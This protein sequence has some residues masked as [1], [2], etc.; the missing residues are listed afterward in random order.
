MGAQPILRQ[1]CS[2]LWIA[3][4][5]IGTGSVHEPISRCWQHS[6]FKDRDVERCSKI[7]KKKEEWR[8]VRCRES[9]EGVDG[10]R[11]GNTNYGFDGAGVISP[12]DVVATI[13]A[14]ITHKCLL[15]REHTASPITL[16]LLSREAQP[17]LLV[18]IPLQRHLRL[19]IGLHTVGV[20]RL[21]HGSVAD[22]SPAR[23]VRGSDLT[24]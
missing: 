23:A 5:D 21:R 4:L 12:D 8:F 3:V 20:K 15:I 11:V 13:W 17:P 22:E 9:T 7:L 10:D 1:F 16:L 6:G 2:V 18:A 14:R 24:R 19:N